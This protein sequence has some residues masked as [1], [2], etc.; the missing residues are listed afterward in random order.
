MS[1]FRHVPDGVPQGTPRL[2]PTTGWRTYNRQKKV[3]AACPELR[4]MA[5]STMETDFKPY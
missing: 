3:K 1:G 4:Q 5:F 2:S